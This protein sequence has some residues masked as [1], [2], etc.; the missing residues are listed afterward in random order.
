MADVQDLGSCVERRAGSSPVVRTKLI[1]PLKALKVLVLSGFFYVLASCV[2]VKT[3][4][5]CTFSEHTNTQYLHS[6]NKKR[7]TA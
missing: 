2:F 6:T 1:Q 3:G 4:S 7:V 5:L